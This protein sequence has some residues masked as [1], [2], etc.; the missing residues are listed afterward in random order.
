MALRPMLLAALSVTAL[1]GC[2]IS[3]DETTRLALPLAHGPISQDAPH[4]VSQARLAVLD[5]TMKRYIDDGKLAGAVVM[6]HQDGREVFSG[7]YG[8]RDREAG[9]RMEKDDIFR[10]ASQTKALTSVGIMMLDRKSVV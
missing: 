7:A 10:I 2:M 6:I 3:V 1:F 4:G 8:W 5:A 9:D